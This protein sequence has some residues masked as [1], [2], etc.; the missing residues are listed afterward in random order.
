MSAFQRQFR[1]T[2][3]QPIVKRINPQ[4]FEETLMMCAESRGAMQ[5]TEVTLKNNKKKTD[6]ITI[7]DID[8][9]N[10]NRTL[11]DPCELYNDNTEH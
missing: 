2:T 5:I 1:I 11:I 9:V 6:T 8:F 4:K 7:V 10:T 3:P